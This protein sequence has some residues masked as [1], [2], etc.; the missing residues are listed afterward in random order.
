MAVFLFNGISL[1]LGVMRFKHPYPVTLYSHSFYNGNAFNPLSL[2]VLKE[3]PI[4]FIGSATTESIP[5]SAI[6]SM[7]ILTG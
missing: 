4:V 1:V 6:I 3:N 5:K 2:L 7:N